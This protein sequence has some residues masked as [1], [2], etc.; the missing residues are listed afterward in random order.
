MTASAQMGRRRGSSPLARGLQPYRR[1]SPACDGIIPA[2][3]GFTTRCGPPTA[4]AA[5][6]PR[7][8]GVY[9]AHRTRTADETGSSPLARGLRTRPR[10]AHDRVRIIPARAGFTRPHRRGSC[11][12]RDHPRSR[13]VYA[14]RCATPPTAGGSS[15]LARGL[16]PSP[17]EYIYT[18]RIIPARAGFTIMARLAVHDL[19]DHPRSRG[20]YAGLNRDMAPARGS[21]PL[22]RGL[23]LLKYEAPRTPR[24]IP[25]R[26]GFTRRHAVS[27]AG[28]SDHPRSRGVYCAC[29]RAWAREWGSSPLARGLPDDAELEA[30]AAGIIP[31]RAGFTRYR[32]QADIMR[33]DHPRSRGVYTKIPSKEETPSGSSPLARGLQGE[34]EEFRGQA[35]IIPARAGFTR[36]D[37]SPSRAWRDHPRSRGVYAGRARRRPAGRRIIPARAGFTQSRRP[38]PASTTGSSPLARGLQARQVLAKVAGRI[39]PARAGFT[40]V[41]AGRRGWRRDHPRSRGVYT[42]V[43]PSPVMVTGSSPLARGLHGSDRPLDLLARIIPARAGF[44]A[45]RAAVYHTHKDH[46]RSRGVYVI[47]GAGVHALEGSS[48]LARGLRLAR[49]TY[50]HPRRI[51]PARAGFT[52]RATRGPRAP[53]DHPRSRGVYPRIRSSGHTRSGSSP[54]ARGLLR[55]QPDG[56]LTWGIIPARAGFTPG[57]TELRLLRADHPRSRGVYDVLEET[58]KFRDGSSPLA[59]GLQGRELVCPAP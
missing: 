27:A 53:R 5:D 24:I 10:H 26:A 46:P 45:L 42:R 43:P 32:S 19:A 21:S 50:G 28:S 36:G 9:T 16:P 20:V 25:A 56:R 40:G 58:Q 17:R 33:E 3:A 14:P 55:P 6:H 7:S 30:E 57:D 41:R 51:I 49:N 18:C 4:T 2:R 52:A 38:T 34:H 35:R 44:T 15:P 11:R 47:R 12:R 39:I 48:P 29:A 22:A 8:R 1:H 59:R 54:L 31:A 23:P 13:G 37:W